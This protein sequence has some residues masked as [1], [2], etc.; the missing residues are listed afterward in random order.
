[1]LKWFKKQKQ[2]PDL[3][4]LPAWHNR[5]QGYV[6]IPLEDC[7]NIH[8]RSLLLD[9]REIIPEKV[10]SEVFIAGGFASHLAGVTDHYTDIDL[11]CLTKD[12][13]EAIERLVHKANRK[14][15]TTFQAI[16]GKVNKDGLPDIPILERYSYR[17]AKCLYKGCLYDLV[18]YSNRI[19]ISTSPDMK[20][21]LN[22]FDFSWGMAG[23]DLSNNT[24]TYHHA[25]TLPYPF[26]N[27]SRVEEFPQGTYERL[28]E[29]NDRL[30]LEPDQKRFNEVLQYVSALPEAIEQPETEPLL[31]Y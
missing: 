24:L 31:G 10:L 18:D 23:I 17:L 4:T 29:Y 30:V 25:A 19:S 2:M 21:L 15:P 1:M 22:T 16:D 5:G 26:I 20:S 9:V 6:S 7:A 28:K 13:F 12:A 8:L 11:F 14:V 3:P 27:V